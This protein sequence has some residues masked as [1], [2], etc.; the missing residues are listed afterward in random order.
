MSRTYTA[1]ADTA[2]SAGHVPCL[3]LV[4]LDFPS[5]FLR[6][7]N[8]GQN[9]EWNGSTWYAG[10]SL[11]GISEIAESTSGEA[12]GVALQLSAVELAPISGS[13]N[14]VNIVQLARAQNYQGRDARVWLAPLNETTFAPIVD[15]VLAF[16][17]RMNKMDFQV[18]E[19]ATFALACESRYA[20]W[21][22]PRVR[23]YNDADQRARFPG[24]R[25]LEYMEQNVEKQLIWRYPLAPKL[26]SL[27][28]PPRND[29]VAPG[30]E[31]GI[32]DLRSTLKLPGQEH[33]IGNLATTPRAADPFKI[34][35]MR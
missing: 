32:G 34:Q 11:L 9:I 19:D 25:G 4:E 35:G 17:G 1:A 18:G 2:L 12:H 26:S 15:P 6:L 29:L 8:A 30:Q 3:M 14:E 27:P 31:H 23:R 24:D 28:I 13:P 22:R 21:N 7:N 20:D 5:G 10:G 33:G 16:E